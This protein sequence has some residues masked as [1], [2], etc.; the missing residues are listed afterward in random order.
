MYGGCAMLVSGANDLTSCCRLEDELNAKS[1]RRSVDDGDGDT[2]VTR[3]R[4]HLASISQILSK[5][6]WSSRQAGHQI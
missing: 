3:R 2:A 5:D 6:F 4:I 1:S